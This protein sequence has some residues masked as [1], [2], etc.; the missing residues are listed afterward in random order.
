MSSYMVSKARL[1]IPVTYQC[2]ACGQR[3][4]TCIKLECEGRQ[5]VNGFDGGVK[6]AKLVAQSKAQ[7]ALLNELHNVY[8]S[9]PE[10]IGQRVERKCPS[11]GAVL[12]WHFTDDET[13]QNKQDGMK[14]CLICAGV[15][16]GLIL[17]VTSFVGRGTNAGLL[18]VSLVL[19]GVSLTALFNPAAKEER[20]RIEEQ[21]NRERAKALEGVPKDCLPQLI[22]TMAE[23]LSQSAK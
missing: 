5:A 22:Y 9:S 8:E 16:V 12:P 13:R 21:G 18:L 23:L 19:I 15:A 10:Q 17:L 2:P 11:C 20:K 7:D 4:F 3:A 14:G 1:D 6:K